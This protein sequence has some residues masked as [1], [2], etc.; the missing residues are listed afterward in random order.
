[1]AYNIGDL[2][3]K[4]IDMKKK[5][6]DLFMGIASDEGITERFKT[7]ARVLAREEKR[8]MLLYEDIRNNLKNSEKKYDVDVDIYDKAAKLFMEFSRQYVEFSKLRCGVDIKD[9][10]ELLEYARDFEKVGMAIILSIQGLFVTQNNY[11]ETEGYKILSEIVKEQ[12][13]HI[14]NIETFIK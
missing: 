9:I 2:L 11:T 1:M 3:E 7:V 4:F 6:Y 10:S 12:E 13:K 5:S 8:H 14:K